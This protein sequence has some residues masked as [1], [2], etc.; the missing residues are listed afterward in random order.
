MTTL[1]QDAGV[2]MLWGRGAAFASMGAMR[3][4]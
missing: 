1:A 3:W 2:V 4:S